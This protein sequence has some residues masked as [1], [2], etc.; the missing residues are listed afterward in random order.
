MAPTTTLRDRGRLTF[1]AEVRRP[2]HLEAGPVLEFK[3]EAGRIVMTPKVL[4][5]AGQAWF[6]SERW[7]TMEREA[8]ADFAGGRAASFDD[9]DGFLD[10]LEG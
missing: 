10:D 3:V 7:Q 4:V 2:A 1:P 6:W 8:D 9:L 5:D